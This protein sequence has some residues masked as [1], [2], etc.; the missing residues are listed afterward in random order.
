[1]GFYFLF[2]VFDVV[3]SE[4]TSVSLWSQNHQR[5]RDLTTHIHTRFLGR[6]K[7][8]ALELPRFLRRPYSQQKTKTSTIPVQVPRY[9]L[10]ISP[11]ARK[12][13]LPIHDAFNAIF[14]ILGRRESEERGTA[15]FYLCIY[16]RR[17]TSDN[18]YIS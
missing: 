14:R 7:A 18:R 15:G 13:V 2:V 1:M 9:R 4:N 6:T 12:Y 5:N 11:L 8:N 3:L 10:E 16:V 17:R